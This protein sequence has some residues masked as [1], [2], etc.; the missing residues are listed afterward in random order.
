MD[1]ISS[2]IVLVMALLINT[3]SPCS[4][5]TVYCV[6]PIA[7]SC[8]S[9]PQNSANCT[10]LSQYAQEAERYF[11]SNT[12]MVFL[13]GDHNLDT[14]IKV[15]NITRFTMCKAS[16][17][18]NKATIVH[19][20]LVG[21]S[22]TSVAEFKVYSLAF[23]SYS[24]NDG[25]L[26]G[27]NSALHLQ[28]I[29]NA[30]LVNCSFH[31]NIGI[32]LEVIDTN[33]IVSGNSDFT[34]NHCESTSCVGSGVVALSSNVTFTGNITFLENFATLYGGGIYISNNSVFNF[35]G[36]INF[37]KNSAGD[38]GG[39]IC[40]LGTNVL[41]ISGT[42]NFT[43]NS[44]TN[45]GGG[46]LLSSNSALGFVGTTNFTNNSA[47]SGGAIFTSYN[48]QLSFNGTSNFINN[49]ADGFGGAIF[50]SHNATLSFNGINNFIN[51]SA[52]DRG[53][54][55]CTSGNTELTFNKVSFF[56]NNFALKG[57]A[58][59]VYTN[60]TLIFN[61]VLHFDSNGHNR[62]RLVNTKNGNM[63][64]GGGVFMGLKSIFSIYRNANVY[65]ENNHAAFGGAIYVADASPLSYCAEDVAL[66]VPKEKC[67]FQL[68]GRNLSDDVDVQFVF[69]NNS[70]DFG[71]SVVYGGAIDNCKVTS[72]DFHSSGKL[73]DMLVHIEDDTN[74]S[75]SSLP[76]SVYHCENNYP[77]YSKS[78]VQY[79]VYPGETFSVSVGASGQ[80]NG[81][82]FPSVIRSYISSGDLQN[83]QYTQK[84][85]NICTTFNYTVFSLPNGFS[86]P[87]DWTLHNST[88]I[89][90]YADS[91][92]STLS[93]ILKLIVTIK[94][95]CPLGFNI[96]KSAKACVCGSRLERY[97]NNCTIIN[98]LGKINRDSSQ[99]FWIGYDHQSDGLILHPL[100]PVDYC[101]ST[102]VIF[103]LNNTDTLCTHNRS[104]L[105]CGACKEG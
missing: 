100:C 57:G 43:G 17:L 95:N 37:I 15:A 84:A 80:R 39:A 92:C 2:S 64:Y 14:N 58:I 97:T 35:S 20:T 73:F 25:I 38:G 87:N 18:G 82:V 22:F 23:T 54:A 46:I 34:H 56:C 26:P 69:K 104:G 4:A 98:G 90:L 8:S 102:P 11:T 103:T 16:Y 68:H 9:C 86:L 10:T 96:S 101:V 65:W 61:T 83:F 74:S 62:G 99:H 71:G 79:E 1:K 63:T 7:T 52:T 77:D 6:T 70:A 40:A 30:E 60:N 44:A 53:G 72:L 50:T 67:F 5:T 66:Y 105:L 31:N 41:S 33:I 13:P 51:N 48:V 29:Q 85:T 45:Y 36:I 42:S 28:S 21:F 94:Q 88:T 59:Y 93:N 12:T 76:F 24:W 89:G 32:A 19:N 91:P 78:A 75:I 47:G 81:T 55:I 3:L 49:S 27:G